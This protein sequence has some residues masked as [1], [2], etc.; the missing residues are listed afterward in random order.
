MSKD[1]ALRIRNSTAEFL[2]FTRQAGE[3]G[4]AASAT[5]RK[6]R[7]VQTEGARQVES[8]FDQFVKEAPRGDAEIAEGGGRPHAEPRCTRSR[9][10]AFPPRPPHLWTVVPRSAAQL[11]QTA[12]PCTLGPRPVAQLPQETEIESELSRDL[13][14]EFSLDRNDGPHAEPRNTRSGIAGSAPRPPRIR[15]TPNRKGG[16]P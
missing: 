7:T 2:I 13:A 4:I 5:I 8:D 3:D 10:S 1:K 11:E 12:T 15:V 9:D 6:F 14:G 16:T